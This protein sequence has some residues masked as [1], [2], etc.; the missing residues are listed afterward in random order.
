MFGRTLWS[1]DVQSQA[2]YDILDY[3][4]LTS[5]KVH[6]CTLTSTEKNYPA[7]KIRKFFKGILYFMNYMD[8][9]GE[10]HQCIIE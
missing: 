1:D 5:F 4:D 7:E 3:F 2:I 10:K 8:K 9:T 6:I